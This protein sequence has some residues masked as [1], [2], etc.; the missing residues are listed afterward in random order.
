MDLS[1]WLIQELSKFRNE[2]VNV[3]RQVPD[4]R[5][6][7]NSPECIQIIVSGMLSHNGA[8]KGTSLAALSQFMT[9][10]P[11]NLIHLITSNEMVEEVLQLLDSKDS[12]VYSQAVR[13]AGQMSVSADHTVVDR[14]I[15]GGY[16]EI[17]N[18]LLG[19][20]SSNLLKEVLWS[21]SNITAG[22]QSQVQAFLRYTQLFERIVILM[23]FPQDNVCDEAIWT[24]ANALQNAEVSCLKQVYNFNRSDLLY[25]LVKAGEKCLKN[26]NMSLL[27][28]LLKSYTTLLQLDEKYPEEFSADKSIDFDFEAAG[29]F[30]F[31]GKLVSHENSTIF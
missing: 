29:G 13:I 27:T 1:V 6:P 18:K 11:M 17:I 3:D 22:T 23:K 5:L 30:D 12:K 26:S 19:S 21:L 15:E 7:F 16:L 24:M 8:I 9:D 20:S 14:L 2:T 25:E 31:V 28:L 4:T 10:M